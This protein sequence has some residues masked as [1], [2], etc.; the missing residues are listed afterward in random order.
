LAIDLNWAKSAGWDDGDSFW[1]WQQLYSGV[2]A[3]VATQTFF[4]LRFP[5]LVSKS[6]K[7]VHSVERRKPKAMRAIKA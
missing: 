2:G 7:E 4:L 6:A 1:T 5:N 3:L